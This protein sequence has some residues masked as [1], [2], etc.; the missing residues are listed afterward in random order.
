LRYVEIQFHSSWKK[1]FVELHFLLLLH[2]VMKMRF[3]LLLLLLQLLYLLRLMGNL[4]RKIKM[5]EP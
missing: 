1:L 2:F 3:L 5:D 4:L